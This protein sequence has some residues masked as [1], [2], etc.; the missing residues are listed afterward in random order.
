MDDLIKLCDELEDCKQKKL[1]YANEIVCARAKLEHYIDGDKNKAL[2]LKAQIDSYDSAPNDPL[3]TVAFF[4]SVATL[5]LT[6]CSVLEDKENYP[7]KLIIVF[8]VLIML[9]VVAKIIVWKIN[10]YGHRR[11]WIRYISVVLED[12]CK[13]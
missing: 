9:I 12:M 13:E 8:W 11:K 4:M 2:K 3:G 7:T 6:I 5:F 1:C 10:K